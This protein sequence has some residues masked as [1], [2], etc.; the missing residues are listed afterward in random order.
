MSAA[1]APLLTPKSGDQLSIRDLLSTPALRGPVILVTAILCLQQLSG[2]NAVLFYSSSV[3][4]SL[5]PNAGAGVLSVGI[6]IVNALMTFPAIFLVDRAGRRSLMLLSAFGM[7][8]MAFL[9]ARGLDGHHANLSAV[10]IVSFIV[11]RVVQSLTL[12]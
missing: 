8:S 7:G 10:A 11:S 6:T 9:L 4:E 2:V 3:L 12:C 5:F 1:A